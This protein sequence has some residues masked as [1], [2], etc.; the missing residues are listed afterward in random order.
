MDIR[1]H[2]KVGYHKAFCLKCIYFEREKESTGRGGTEREGERESQQL[3]IPRT[4]D[5]MNPT[6][7]EIMTCAEIKSQTLN[8]LSHPGAPAIKSLPESFLCLFL[9]SIFCLDFL[10]VGP[11]F[12]IWLTI[13]YWV[14]YTIDVRV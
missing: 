8:Q 3:G 12:N 11:F 13:Y 10:P 6:N 14:L 1:G 2:F 9:F 7:R 5:P 4:W